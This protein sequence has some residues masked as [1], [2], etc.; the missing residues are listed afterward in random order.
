MGSVDQEN[1]SGGGS[2]LVDESGAG[3][4]TLDRLVFAHRDDVCGVVRCSLVNAAMWPVVVV[5]L[6]V[7]LE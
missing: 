4:V 5:V 3:C 7:F 2:V 6:D 1:G